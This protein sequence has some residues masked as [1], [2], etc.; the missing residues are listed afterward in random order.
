MW[1]PL[2]R[3][4]FHST[5]GGTRTPNLLIRSQ[6]RGVSTITANRPNS[7]CGNGFGLSA[8]L[9]TLGR[10]LTS[11]GPNADQTETPV[12]GEPL[13]DDDEHAAFL[14]WLEELRRSEVA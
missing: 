6:N 5:P 3:M 2:R 4:R 10:F 14:T 8:F 13:F 12:P 7:L 9:V 1:K 11:R